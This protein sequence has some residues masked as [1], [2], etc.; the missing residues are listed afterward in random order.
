MTTETLL[1]EL[2]TEELPPKALQ[3]L[4]EAFAAEIFRDLESKDFLEAGAMK[5]VFAS[6]R[7]LAVQVTN[8]RKESPPKEVRRK[9]MPASVALDKDGKATP[10]LKKK[11]GTLGYQDDADFDA[12]VRESVTREQDGKNEVL[13]LRDLAA[14]ALLQTHLWAAIEQAI[15]KLPIPKVMSYQLADGETTVQ[16]VRPVHRL[17]AIHGS[18]VVPVG[19]LGLVSSNITEGHRF[20][21][22]KIIT[23]ATANDYEA[24]LESKGGVIPSFE[25]RRVEID[26]QLRTNASKQNAALETGDAYEA[27]LDEVTALVEMPT[28]YVGQFES[29]FL[30][31]PQECLM[32]TMRANQKYFPLLDSAGKL[33]NKFL[34]VSNMKLDDA[35]NIISGNERVIRPRLA[36]AK[37]FFDQDRKHSL[38]SRLPKLAS[39]V[40]HNKLGSMLDRVKRIE[41]IAA[42]IAKQ[43]SS[44][45]IELAK[46]AALLCK[47]DLVTDMVGEFP[48][49]QGLMGGYYARHDGESESVALAI[50][51]QY[52]LREN[53][54]DSAENLTGQILFLAEKIETLVGIFG[55]GLAPTGDKDPFALRRSAFGVIETFE[56]FGA[57]VRLDGQ[58]LTLR[59]RDLLN[60]GSS[61]F[62]GFSLKAD[63]V[64]EVMNFV[65]ERYR[66]KLNGI[67][68]RDAVEAVFALS[69]ELDEVVKR[70]RAVT[71]FRKL[72]EAESLAAANKRI[73]NIL[74]KANG[75]DASTWSESLLVEPAE[76]ELARAL[77][78]VRPIAQQ[79]FA[80]R[81]Y[82][83]A[84]TKLA[85]LK[86][87]VDQFF[88]DVMVMADDENVRR[89]RLALLKDLYGLMN[90]VADISKLAS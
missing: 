79:S 75:A 27:L 23:L 88:N 10:A 80:S 45:H 58:A 16:F 30:D 74:K 28:V 17:V 71:E 40:Y 31:V 15:Q 18:E 76:K 36:D 65:Y 32:L 60:L 42:Y 84:L 5:T 12:I 53:K 72:V 7:R 3:K 38:E 52:K 66:N 22:E 8:V 47:A 48:E 70:I 83:D 33:T 81:Q 43:V 63:V 49:L 21:G 55:I 61:V 54:S 51:S 87:P 24:V 86:T 77:T 9:L 1:V 34:I 64:D 4:G 78:S 46:R 20:Q 68:D 13:V 41:Q 69:P 73:G 37:F 2:L 59:L 11:L 90:Q 89:N 25:K 39:I 14:G 6:P 67:F 57:M 62:D 82:A 44:D 50:A 56:L 85:A 19:V 29:V 35:T 26:R